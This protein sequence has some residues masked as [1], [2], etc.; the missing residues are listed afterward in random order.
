MKLRVL[1]TNERA[2]S[3][4]YTHVLVIT[5]DDLTVTTVAT[6]QTLTVCPLNAGDQIMRVAWHL[7]RAFENT[8]DAAYAVQTVSVGDDAGVAT[9]LAAGE[10][11]INGTEL[12]WRT[13][14]TVVLYTAGSNLTVTFTAPAAGKAVASLN[15]G[16]L[17]IYFALSRLKFIS[18]AIAS[19]Q[20]AKT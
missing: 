6:L 17:L 20:I 9:H 4:G 15:R 18:D 16:E 11:N 2:E 7:R 13:G 1:T 19:S 14:N 12:I 5:A 8:A 10:V 3:P